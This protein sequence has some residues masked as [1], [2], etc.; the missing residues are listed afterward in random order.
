MT[1]DRAVLLFGETYHHPNILYRTGFLAPDP[2]VVV[3]RGGDD[4]TLWVSVLEEGR[5]RKE[6]RAGT[7]RSTTELNIAEK[8]RQAGSEQDAWSL[9][10]QEVC[11]THDL[12]SVTV[13]A[14]FPAL[15]ADSLRA[16]DVE[17]VPRSDLYRRERRIKTDD[18]IRRI[19][20]EIQA[21]HVA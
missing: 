18:E 14:D 17:V 9:L 12:R 8:M 19:V 6:A 1:D 4:T 2:V 16:G 11:R 10:L 13:D 7:V 21:S 5:A 15:I 20:G 3:D